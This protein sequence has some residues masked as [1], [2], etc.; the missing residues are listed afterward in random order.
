M[1]ANGKAPGKRAESGAVRG[2]LSYKRRGAN[3]KSKSSSPA[4][5][6]A[7]SSQIGKSSWVDERLGRGRGRCFIWDGIGSERAIVAVRGWL[8]GTGIA[9][10]RA[11]DGEA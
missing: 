11:G 7:R 3:E 2:P 6:S 4:P 1:G 8:E 9:L 5:A 10:E